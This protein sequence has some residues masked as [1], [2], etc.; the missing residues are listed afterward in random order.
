MIWFAFSAPR[1]P[2]VAGAAAIP[3]P[4]IPTQLPVAPP[5]P[6]RAVAQPFVADELL[7]RFE[8]NVA[9]DQKRQLLAGIG[10]VSLRS[11]AHPRGL[12][13][14]RLPAG[15]GVAAAQLYFAKQREVTSS[16]PNLLYYISQIPNDPLFSQLW[17]LNGNDPTSDDSDPDMDAPAGWDEST[18]SDQVVVAV[19]DTGVDYRH[20]DLS[21][22]MW[23]N[24]R[25]IAGNGV[26]D[27]RNGWI[28]DV[29]GIDPINGD[30][31]PMDDQSHGTHVAGTIAARGNDGVGVAGLN[32]RSKIVACKFLDSKG[33]G[34]LSDALTCYDYIAAL[35]DAGVN[36]VASNNSWGGGAYSQLLHDAIAGQRQRGI[37]FV[38][39]AGNAGLDVD[40]RPSYPGAYDLDNII[41][42]A[43]MDRGGNR[44]YFSNYGA[45]TVDIAAPGVDILSTVPNGQWS[46]RSGTSMAAPHVA[47]LV[48]LLRANDPTMSAAATKQWILS[49]ATDDS[50]WHGYTSSGRRARV[51]LAVADRDADGMSDR[52]EE[53]FALNP[54]DP[55]DAALD[56]DRDRLTNVDEYRANTDPRASDTD[57]DG[58]ADGA[59]V[60]QAHTNPLRADTDDDGLSDGEEVNQRRTSPLRAD[61]DADGLT[62]KREVELGTDPLRADTDGDGLADGWEHQYAFD[63]LHAGEAPAD[64]DGDGLNNL[65]EFT[66]GTR[67]DLADT[68]SDGLTDGAEVLQRGTHPTSPDSDGD[69]MTDGWEVQHGFNPL[70]AADADVDTD[71]DGFSNRSEF[72]AGSDPRDATSRPPVA[73]WVTL[74]GNSSHA[75]Y[76]PV[77]TAASDF[78][79]RWQKRAGVASAKPEM[80]LARERV[81]MIGFNQVPVATAL[82]LFDGS[83]AWSR[84]LEDL[85]SAGPPA[86]SGSAVYAMT[87]PYGVSAELTAFDLEDGSTRFSAPRS[88]SVDQ[89][90]KPQAVPFDDALYSQEAD[91]IASFDASTGARRWY[92]PIPGSAQGGLLTPAVDA[93]HV[94]VYTGGALRIFNRTSG[95]LLANN[96]IATCPIYS[97]ARVILD[98]A[99]D[100]YVLHS[101]CIAKF[102]GTTGQLAWVYD[103]AD[104]DVDPAVDHSAI[105]IGGGLP[106]LIALNLAN[107]QVMWSAL[108][109]VQSRFNIVATLD[110]VFVGSSTGSF[111]IDRATHAV[112]WTFPTS[113][114]LALTDEGALVISQQDGNVAVVNIE[115]DSDGDG[116]PGWWERHFNLNPRGATDAALDSD[117]DALTNL[118]EYQIGSNPR[119]ADSDDDGLLDGV[120]TNTLGTDPRSADSDADGLSDGDEVKRYATDP[121]QADTDADGTSDYDETVQYHTDPRDAASRPALLST[122]YES[123]ESG[124]PSGWISGA[125]ADSGWSV[126]ALDPPTRG[127]ALSA[128]VIGPHREAAVE[129]TASFV[130]G[131]VSFDADVDSNWNG[132][133]RVFVDDQQ[134]ASVRDGQLQ[135]VAVPVPAGTHTLRWEFSP[136]GNTQVVSSHAYIDNVTFS[137]PR[138]FASDSTHM[139]GVSGGKL[140]EF[141]ADGRQARAPIVIPG[142]ERP[143]DVVVTPDHRI[144]IYD[145]PFLHLF[146]PV[147]G[148]FVRREVPGWSPYQGLTVSNNRILAVNS[149]SSG[150]L[151]FTLD[152]TPIDV[153]LLGT[154]YIDIESGA[155]G[156]LYG[157]L[158]EVGGYDRI[159]PATMTV[160]A[161]SRLDCN[162]C[163][164]VT[165]DARGDFYLPTFDGTIRHFAP[166]GHLVGTLALPESMVFPFD[167]DRSPGGILYFGGSAGDFGHVRDNFTELVTTPRVDPSMSDYI[168]V[169]FVSRSGPDAD[170]DGMP[171]WWERYRR[172]NP[173]SNDAAVDADGDGLS[174]R[175]E[176][177]QDTDPRLADTDA[178]GLGDAAELSVHQTS[179]RDADSDRDGLSDGDEVNLRHTDPL[180]VDSD[181]DG[182]SDGDEVNVRHSDPGNVDSDHD[183]AADG[184]E[185]TNGLNPLD[186]GDA[187]LDPDGDGLTNVEEYRSGADLRV[188]DTDRDRLDDGIE[189]HLHHTDP[190]QFDTD[191]DDLGDG[192]EVLYG[193]DALSPNGTA[194]P[195]GDGFIN[196]IEFFAG[197]HPTNGSSRPQ[198]SAWFTHQGDTR[199]RGYVPTRSSASAFRELWTQAV[200]DS[201]SLNQVASDSGRVYVSTRGRFARNNALTAL[202]AVS[203]DVLWQREFGFNYSTL[204][205]PAV[206]NG[207]V[208]VQTGGHEAS[209]L[210]GFGTGTGSPNL[211]TP[212]AAQW[213]TLLA[214]APLGGDVYAYAGY[215]GGVSSFDGLHNRQRWNQKLPSF[216][217]WSPAVDADSIYTYTG[218]SVSGELTVLDRA[219]GAVRYRVTDPRFTFRTYS[220]DGSPILGTHDDLIVTRPRGL[221]SFDLVSRRI[222]WER[223]GAGLSAQASLANGVIYIADGASLAALAD[224]SGA[225]LWRWAAP[226]AITHPIVVTIDHAFVSG[227]TGTYAIDLRTHA[228]VWR[229]AR[230]GELSLGNDGVLYIAADDGQLS[231]IVTFAD[232]DGDLMPD[233]WEQTNGLAANDAGDARADGDGDGL[234]NRDEY[235]RH[236]D[237]ARGDTDGDGL[238]DGDEVHTGA[239]DPRVTDTDRDGLSD[240]DE[241]RRQTN[242]GAVDTDSDGAADGDEV[243]RG[244]DPSNADSDGDGYNDGWEFDQGTSP[245]NAAS[246]PLQVR[247]LFESFESGTVPTR[248]S[249]G[250]SGWRAVAGGASDG[251][252]RLRSGAI[253]D[254]GASAIEWTEAFEEGELSFDVSVSAEPQSDRFSFF[255]DGVR[256]EEIGDT[257]WY[258]FRLPLAAGT[259]T[260]RW[261]YRKDAAGSAGDDAAYIDD[262]RIAIR[263]TDADSLPD[264]WERSYG[265]NPHS[266]AD[267]LDDLDGDGLHN[268]DEYE[269]HT[270]PD[271]ADSESD[272]IPDGWEVINGLDPLTNDAAADPDGDGATN[273]QEYTARTDPK[274]AASKPPPSG[275]GGGGTGGGTGGGGNVDSGGGGGGAIDPVLLCGFALLLAVRIRRRARQRVR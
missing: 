127:H 178:D 203:G 189:L 132:T 220:M 50:R 97:S 258:R 31:D 186:A 151:R 5:E 228:E 103:G 35:K 96:S 216:D 80:T 139:L 210:F 184:W 122:Y 224:R 192:W 243:R 152:G 7:V 82:N 3:T 16:E 177:D 196:T 17:G 87:Q 22:N 272:G 167:I 125:N 26:D 191:G 187:A 148:Q 84:R 12:E 119:R 115:G 261:E 166:D 164:S 47:G 30:A 120:E 254:N 71:G 181:D 263:D 183:G 41:N 98:G 180:D 157:L 117:G 156:Y 134:L 150:L 237:P 256:Y 176:F 259:H 124:F 18:G 138:P 217:G 40:V 146:D 19:V 165:V 147:S 141:T 133:L 135:R 240:G 230:G 239:S 6:P 161:S 90:E 62:D 76:L 154:R 4:L 38:A 194:D 27:D 33:V 274:N 99:G 93:N 37:L 11:Y 247:L 234:S 264:A 73:P 70:N 131:D 53:R 149:G 13:L 109:G 246:R 173:V 207:Q 69:V 229:Y 75:G 185:V 257:P 208:Y 55:S 101:G 270:R 222:A 241:V 190:T 128:V 163:F 81:V 68:D 213:P 223:D 233:A 242:P 29:R 266:P 188:A 106:G 226:E 221:L 45:D 66:A 79:L 252:Y 104:P 170:G 8:P 211:R 212:Y 268:R 64:P 86:V 88:G 202:E 89:V 57:H 58:L 15:V 10:A 273:A 140:Y 74:Q 155:D 244:S 44:A 56:P 39:A 158:D 111:A 85:N 255:L 21:E 116:M 100:V 215:N 248:W 162:Q 123:F 121:R 253:G 102:S 251:R 65:R 110:H 225:D 34:E 32:W 130:G 236:T 232:A 9:A 262:L 144:A 77:T 197:T 113:G 52:W 126:A 267:A 83:V 49:T 160:I 206:A 61:S 214:P 72:R 1:A 23:T 36:I 112:A 46:S 218:G 95:A 172:L 174:N 198:A 201:L 153:A 59:E 92:A 143:R 205:P 108:A 250:L 129:W 14:I 67:P 182:L 245:L 24:P 91:G 195:D 2:T 42:V 249:N 114:R 78:S 28:D 51:S 43:A 204:S 159:D 20:I 179:P 265:L 171:D 168:S 94:V 48:A 199:H 25:E 227:D 145:A 107:G 269:R 235:Y 175:N 219:N 271:A 142:A 105:Y 63:P 136:G 238:S 118:R 169:T 200:S 209:Y 275:T 137:V 54:L 193:F 60:H 260:L 231:A